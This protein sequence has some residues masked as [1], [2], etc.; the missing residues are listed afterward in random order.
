MTDVKRTDDQTL[1]YLF[2]AGASSP[3]LPLA[4]DVSKRMIH[5]GEYLKKE[6]KGLPNELNKKDLSDMSSELIEWGRQATL[7]YSVDT[8]AKK[9][10][11]TNKQD[12]LWRLKAAMSAF[13][14]I[15]Q[16][17]SRAAPRYDS[18]FAAILE[19]PGKPP[20]I[21]DH[22]WLLTWNYD[23]QFERAYHQY[24]PDASVLT[25]K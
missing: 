2:G 20:T 3:S 22:I 12:E 4:R 11:L 9:L 16:A 14:M 17:A 15:E 8:L 10:F 5:W 6:A 1:L 21:P 13:F 18:F 7:H 25:H 23:R 24:C 19:E